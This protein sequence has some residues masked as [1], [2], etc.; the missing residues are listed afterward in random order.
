ME[1]II[2]TIMLNLSSE[3]IKQGL[4]MWFSSSKKDPPDN[5]SPPYGGTGNNITINGNNNVIN[6]TNKTSSIDDSG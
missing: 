6:Y 3:A 1:E 5:F 2:K 4:K